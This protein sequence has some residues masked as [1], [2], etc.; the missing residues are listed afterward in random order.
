MLNE[1]PIRIFYCDK[2]EAMAIEVD[3]PFWGTGF[4]TEDG[5]LLLTPD[6][7]DW[8]YIGDL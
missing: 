4:E 5:S 6:K 7:D 3:W 1:A 8:K 2:L